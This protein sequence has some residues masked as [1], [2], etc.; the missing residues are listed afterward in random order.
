MK[1]GTPSDDPERP[2]PVDNAIEIAEI[3]Y[4]PY[5][6]NVQQ[7][8]IQYLKHKRFQMKD[9]KK[10]E[11]RVRNLEYYTSLSMLESNT[12]NMFVPDN[13]G[14]N[15]F[16]SGFFVDNFTSFKS[17]DYFLSRKYSID[18]THKLMR[19]SH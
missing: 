10:L 9:I 7:I 3:R 14:L 1:F 18:K 16:K 19:R 6:H 5:L 15:R 11:D 8:S 4:P 2:N 12:A 13:E 17:Q